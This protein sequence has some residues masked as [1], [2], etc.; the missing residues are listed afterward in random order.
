MEFY[1][2]SRSAIPVSVTSVRPVAQM[3]VPILPLA[4][5]VAKN[6]LEKVLATRQEDAN[7]F[8]DRSHKCNVPLPRKRE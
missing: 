2:D 1:R 4:K 5:L 8:K 6:L 7:W 3:N